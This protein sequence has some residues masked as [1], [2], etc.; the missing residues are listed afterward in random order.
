MV[1]SYSRSINLYLNTLALHKNQ[2]DPSKSRE[3]F[4]QRYSIIFQKT[5]IFRNTALRASNLACLRMVKAVPPVTSYA[6]IM[7]EWKTLLLLCSMQYA[8]CSMQYF[9]QLTAH[10][11]RN[12]YLLFCDV[13]PTC[14]GPCRPSSGRTVTKE[15]HC[16]KCREKCAYM[17]LKFNTIN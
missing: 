6:F 13:P 10:V 17:G 1:P 15:Y 14:F 5:C 16:N 4:T 7:G 11:T 8:V 3:L 12:N 2:N 9:I